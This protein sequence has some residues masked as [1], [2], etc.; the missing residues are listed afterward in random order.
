MA[1]G[2]E[3]KREKRARRRNSGEP[4]SGSWGREAERRG[5]VRR[6]A[7]RNEEKL[8]HLGWSGRLR[9]K[10]IAAWLQRDAIRV[11]VG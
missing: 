10:A 5:A 9:S 3:V 7:S 8:G 4:S 11:D 1:H 6:N 2:A